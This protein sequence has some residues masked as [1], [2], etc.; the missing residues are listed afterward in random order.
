M[1]HNIIGFDVKKLELKVKSV[2]DIEKI[3][4]MFESG[5]GEGPHVEL[6]DE[7]FWINR[8]GEGIEMRFRE[9]KGEYVL[10]HIQSSGTFSGNLQYTI[11]EV[12]KRYS[13]KIH[14]KRTW[15]DGEK[16]T[17]KVGYE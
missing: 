2:I 10:E 15:E 7:K 13:G 6:K 5:L 17:L 1:S 12:F 8:N 3:A 11:E 4:G 14:V 16:D 9:E